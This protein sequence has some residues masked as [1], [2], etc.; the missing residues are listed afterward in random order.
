MIRIPES[1]EGLLKECRI[2]TFRAS[3]KGGQHVNKTDS[4]VR[5]THLPTGIVV[6]CQDER[7]QR[8]NKYIALDRLRKKLI[9]L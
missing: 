2:D 6:T 8:R 3:G 4:A 7:S 9:V 1:N 5:L